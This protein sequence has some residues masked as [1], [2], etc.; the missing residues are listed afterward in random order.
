MAFSFND[1]TDKIRGRHF[2]QEKKNK[3]FSNKVEEFQLIP[4]A[5]KIDYTQFY[6]KVKYVY[7][8][9]NAQDAFYRIFIHAM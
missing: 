7:F 3:L 2:K 1:S 4:T 6:R 9:M 8:Y 5:I